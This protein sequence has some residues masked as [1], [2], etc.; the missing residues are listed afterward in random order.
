[1]VNKRKGR[2]ERRRKVVGPE[3]RWAAAPG[4]A[5]LSPARARSGQ[6]GP[7]GRAASTLGSLITTG[8]MTGVTSCPPRTYLATG[9]E[10]N[11]PTDPS[12]VLAIHPFTTASRNGDKS[13]RRLVQ[14]DS[15]IRIS[16]S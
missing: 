16:I 15:V 5:G 10:L 3:Q 6:A 11:A 14:S 9:I 4:R 1:M 2:R 12:A 8:P 13:P 7:I